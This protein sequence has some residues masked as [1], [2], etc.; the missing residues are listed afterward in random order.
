MSFYVW[1]V[2]FI[3]GFPI[4]PLMWFIDKRKHGRVWLVELGDW[5]LRT[6]GDWGQ[7]HFVLVVWFGRL[8]ILLM[9]DFRKPGNINSRVWERK[10]TGRVEGLEVGS[11]LRYREM[12]M[13]L[14]EQESVRE[15]P[16][17]EF[18]VNYDSICALTK[19]RRLW[20]RIL[21]NSVRDFENNVF[22]SSI[23][24]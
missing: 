21:S 11:H 1:G 15:Y 7:S 18:G 17:L 12:K 22:L 4:Y 5:R 10:W 20:N 3:H 19:E 14:I 6:S 16:E 2:S 13:S 24:F 9:C 8:C 23:Y